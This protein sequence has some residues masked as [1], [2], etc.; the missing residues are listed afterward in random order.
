LLPAAVGLPRAKALL[1]LGR[2]FD[3]DEAQRWGLVWRVADDDQAAAAALDVATQLAGGDA[4]VLGDIKAL[5]HRSALHDVGTAL[6][7]ESAVHERLQ[8]R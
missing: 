8:Q 2:E 3:A 6:A 1:M 7:R 4:A 5:L